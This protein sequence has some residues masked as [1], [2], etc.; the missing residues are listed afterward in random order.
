MS[1]SSQ[2]QL[3]A[4]DFDEWKTLASV[5]PEAFERRRREVIE[6]YLDNLPPAKQR[7]LR[8][9]QFR[10]DME[11]RRARTPMGACL[12]ISS[13]MWDS[14]V[15]PDGLTSSIKLLTQPRHPRALSEPCKT[16]ARIL[17]FRRHDNHAR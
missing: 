3:Q 14:L 5:D 12:K 6:H 13:M 16:D 8:G 4:F 7:R 10:I 15:G 11:R 1:R 17:Q 2:G 9:L